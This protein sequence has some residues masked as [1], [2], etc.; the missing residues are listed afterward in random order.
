MPVKKRIYQIDLLRFV[1]GVGIMLVHYLYR[2]FKA[3]KLKFLG[4]YR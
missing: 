3:D 4:T 1:T 2:G